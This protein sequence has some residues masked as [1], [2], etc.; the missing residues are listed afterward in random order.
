MLSL[1]EMFLV[2]ESAVNAETDMIRRDRTK[3]G[4]VI[5][6]RQFRWI[7]GL[8]QFQNRAPPIWNSLLQCA[9]NS[10]GCD[11]FVFGKNCPNFD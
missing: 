5:R 4:S 2:A 6:N 9:L 1:Q 3:L 7:M 11:S 8:V 10:H